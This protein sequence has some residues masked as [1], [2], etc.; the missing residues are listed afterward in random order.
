MKAYE[1]FLNLWKDAEA[2][3]P[4]LKQAKTEGPHSSRSA[5]NGSSVAARRAGR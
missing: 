3:L 5:S 4:I 2:N 1:E